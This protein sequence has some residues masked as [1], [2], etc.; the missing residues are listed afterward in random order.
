MA[1]FRAG[2]PRPYRAEN[3]PP[4]GSSGRSGDVRPRA[5]HPRSGA[6]TGA[7]TALALTLIAAPAVAQEEEDSGSSVIVNGEAPSTFAFNYGETETTR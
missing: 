2:R 4:R 6:S 5:H 1:V 7:F 3:P